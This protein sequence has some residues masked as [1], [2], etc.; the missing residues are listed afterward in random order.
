MGHRG[1]IRRTV[2]GI[3]FGVASLLMLAAPAHALSVV[4]PDN[5]AYCLTGGK[6]AVASDMRA[7]YGGYTINDDQSITCWYYFFGRAGLVPLLTR[8]SLDAE[9]KWLYGSGA[10]GEIYYFLLEPRACAIP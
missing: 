3:A 7:H 5:T 4:N 10:Y 1:T 6:S 9:C 8:A 2:T